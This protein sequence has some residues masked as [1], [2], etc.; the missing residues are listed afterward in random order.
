MNWTITNWNDLGAVATAFAFVGAALGYLLS[1][2]KGWSDE[3]R[4]D[5]L[6][7]TNYLLLDLL[8]DWLL[9]GLSETELMAQYRTHASGP[10]G[11]HYGALPAKKFS[12]LDLARHLKRLQFDG[13]IDLV[14]PGQ[15]RIRFRSQD[16]YEA[17]TRASRLLAEQ[18]M[19]KIGGPE[20]MREVETLVGKQTYSHEKADLLQAAS[21]LDPADSAQSLLGRMK[22]ADPAEALAAARTVLLALDHLSPER[23]REW[24]RRPAPTVPPRAP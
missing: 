1:L 11:R 7:G 18:V 12:E 2:Y 14:G 9:D 21:R 22:S 20:L 23:K 5:R 8:D 4:D 6:R 3:R 17:E 13:L 16:R 15:Y 19:T 24:L 10:K